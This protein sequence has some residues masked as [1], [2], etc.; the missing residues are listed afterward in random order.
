MGWF[1]NMS[2]KKIKNPI[3]IRNTY[4]EYFSSV[5]ISRNTTRSIGHIPFP[6]KKGKSSKRTYGN[7]NNKSYMLGLR[8]CLKLIK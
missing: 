8:I 1:K 7:I 3:D 5:Y 4:G 2:E 6:L